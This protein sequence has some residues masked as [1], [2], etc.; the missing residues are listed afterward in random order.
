[1]QRMEEMLVDWC[2]GPC[3][4]ERRSWLGSTTHAAR[5]IHMGDSL[6][7]GEFVALRLANRWS[8]RKRSTVS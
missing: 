6:G 1:M 7:G 3:A 2:H 4:V 8:G 5:L